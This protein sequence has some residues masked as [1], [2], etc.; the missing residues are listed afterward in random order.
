MHPATGRAIIDLG[1]HGDPARSAAP[2]A[3]LVFFSLAASAA[4]GEVSHFRSDDFQGS[5]SCAPC[6]PRQY[7][8][9]RGSAHAYSLLDP[10]FLAC[11]NYARDST[12]GAIGDHCL[13]CHAPIGVR[14]GELPPDFDPENVPPKIREGVSCETCHRMEPAHEG[15]IADANFRLA[16]GNTF[17]G[18]LHRPQSNTAHENARS[19]FL[20][21]SESC[22]SCH[23]VIL[24]YLNVESAYAEWSVSPFAERD[25]KCQDCHMLRYSGQA[26]V[27]GPF[28]ETLRRHNFPAST[29]PPPGFP[30]R[31]YQL[32]E[33]G[34]FLRTAV[35]AAVLHP[36]E[37]EA[38][39]TL[40][41]TV[42]LKNSGTGHNF[43]G[44]SFRQLWVELEVEDSSGSAIFRSGHLDANGDLRDKRSSLSPGED[45]ALASFS[46]YFVNSDGAEVPYWFATASVQRSLASLE[47]R[48]VPYRVPVPEALLGDELRI[49]ARLLFRAF[50]GA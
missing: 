9:W 28:R 25:V 18:R 20:G 29:L 43:P 17:Y 35:R 49:R 22:G 34:A 1:M 48:H 19:E 3:L 38:G 32:E 4:A 16:P 26:A 10:V 46:D 50:V 36:S 44:A 37:A 42:W 12:A 45:K 30:N 2:A 24:G 8:E 33:V 27:G 40:P 6:H 41:I 47:E 39:G 13:R 31:G 21:R 23:D 14:S 5:E 15:P 7:L 11:A